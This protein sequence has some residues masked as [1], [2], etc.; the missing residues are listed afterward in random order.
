M[1]EQK[2]AKVKN[3]SGEDLTVAWLNNRL[4]LAG[5]AVE[6][7]VE[8]VFAYTQQAETWEPYD[9]AAKKVHKEHHEAALEREAA[10]LAALEPETPEDA[11]EQPEPA[12]T[13][14]TQE[15]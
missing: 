7:P 11:G 9:N 15:G 5:Q 14:A 1:A 2:T 8:D 12:T 13:S 10:E 6:V 3:V 4:V